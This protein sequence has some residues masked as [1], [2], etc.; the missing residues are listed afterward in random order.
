LTN[1]RKERI[2]R[3][4]VGIA[5]DKFSYTARSVTITSARR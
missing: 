2:G 3:F 5:H 1:P 4:V